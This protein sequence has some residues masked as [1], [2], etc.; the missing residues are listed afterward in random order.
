MTNNAE[1]VIPVGEP[2]RTGTTNI[3]R[4]YVQKTVSE[5]IN[6]LKKKMLV[7]KTKI[8][9]EIRLLTIKQNKSSLLISQT[10]KTSKRTREKNLFPSMDTFFIKTAIQL[11]ERN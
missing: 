8:P 6:D 10:R 3:K 2:F 11:E 5:E 4:I 7:K 9:K 1:S